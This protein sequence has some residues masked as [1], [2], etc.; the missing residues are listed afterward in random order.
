MHC[1]RILGSVQDAEDL[2]Q[3]TLLAAWRGLA[4]LRGPRV[5][6]RRGC[7]GSPRTAA[8]TRC[9]TAAAARAHDGAGAPGRRAGADPAGASRSGCSPTP[10]RCSRA[11]PTAPTAPTRATRRKEAV[12]L[13]FVS[14]LQ[15]MPPPPARGARAARRARLP[16]RRGGGRCSAA[17]EASVNSALQRA[18]AALDGGARR[19]RGGAA[20]PS[21]RR[22][23]RCV[24]RFADA[25]ERG[26]VDAVV[27]LLTEDA[28]IRM[29]PEPHE[30]QGRAGDRR[31]P[32][33]AARSGATAAASGSCPPG[34]TAQPAFAYYLGD[35]HGRRRAR[36]RGCSCS[37]RGR[38]DP[39]DHA[40]RRHAACCP[41]S[42]CR[43]RCRRSTP[44]S[45]DAQRNAAP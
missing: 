44:T 9:A 45:I 27:A 43:G 28:W 20:S 31:V 41:S 37:R 35:P 36:R 30:Y 39:R 26:D 13:A 23:R 5:A 40:L 1:Y 38:R 6:A 22:A 7:T 34:P 11:C 16:R 4:R 8:S 15:R 2:V 21:R 25:F 18:R 12:G 17:S 3:E 29:P 33:H 14:G 42:G 19:G 32:A 10:T 24:T